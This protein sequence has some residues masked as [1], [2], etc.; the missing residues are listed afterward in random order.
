MRPARRRVFSYT[1]L[2]MSV[3]V[4]D[5]VDR[6]TVFDALVVGA[7][8]A[9][10]YLGY[11]LAKSGRRVAIIDKERFPRDKVCGGAV[12]RKAIDL[13]DFDIAPVVHRSVRG[14]FLTF[15]NRSTV[16]KDEERAGVCTVVRSE[17]DQ[18]LL[19]KAR[20]AG[21]QFFPEANFLGAV[22]HDQT[23]SV[24]TSRG[25][26]EASLVCA[27][28]GAASAVRAKVFGKNVVRYVPSLEALV[29]VRDSEMSRL[30]GRAVFDFGVMPRGYGWIFPK[31]DHLNVG[32]YS[33]F[34]GHALRAHLDRFISLYRSM[35]HPVS[36]RYLGFVI[37]VEN[38]AKRFQH[39]RI[40]LIGDAAG[41][42]ECIFGEGIYFAL[43]SA[44]VAA[45]AIERGGDA[46]DSLLYT[47][48]LN[49]ELLPEL[50]AS[51]WIGKALYRF[52]SFSFS[53]LVLNDRV[54]RDFAGLIT[55]EVGYRQCLSLTA[56]NAFKWLRR[57]PSAD[58]GIA[59]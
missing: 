7:G 48:S 2:P 56:R 57:S 53:H 14:A 36:I 29:H 4:P 42:V 27:A 58:H 39:G 17:F 46:P 13:I 8:P 6:A 49:Q 3:A 11:L 1:I 40:W 33:P 44:V 54:N 41:L 18:F 19:D 15:G 10:S 35:R 45:D 43:K 30:D 50:R 55:G 32:V 23:V 47:K 9:G 34:G 52:Q 22:E 21:A 25:D 28:D 24:K 51:Q 20:A 59:L 12:S 26:F 38:A 31:S 16:V 5:A 37:P